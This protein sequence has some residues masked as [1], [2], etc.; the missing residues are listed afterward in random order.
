MMKRPA[1]PRILY[2]T[3]CYLLVFASLGVIQFTSGRGFSRR[4]GD[5]VITGHYRELR[6]DDPPPGPQEYPLAGEPVIA[7]GGME[8]H[9]AGGLAGGGE[10]GGLGFLDAGGEKWEA[11]PDSMVVSGTTASFYFPGGSE[12]IFSSLYTE[13]VPELRIS[14]VFAGGIS[15]AEIPYRISRGAQAAADPDGELV[16]RSG[17]KSY[18]FGR[19]Q[20]DT[21]RRVLTLRD[22]GGPVSYRG[23]R[24]K[25]AFVPEEYVVPQAQDRGRYLE[26]L[27]RWRDQ[28]YALWNRIAG[29]GGDEDLVSA[30]VGES[31]GRGTY[32]AALA[33]LSPN[34]LAA[35]ARSYQSSVYLGRMDAGLLSL[36]AFERDQTGRLIRQ[37]NDRSPDFIR[38]SHVFAYLALRGYHTMVDRGAELIRNLDSAL[39]RPDMLPGILEGFSDWVLHRPGEENPFASL[40]PQVLWEVSEGIRRLPGGEGVYFFHEGRGDLEF[41]LRLGAALAALGDD[42]EWAAWTTLGRS[43]VLSVLAPADAAGSVPRFLQISEEDGEIREVPGTERLGS[44][45]LYGILAAGGNDRVFSAAYYPRAVNTGADGL[46][47]WTAASLVEARE[48][49]GVLDIAVTFPAGEAHYM[50]LRGLR[51][52]TKIQLYDMDYRTDPQFERYDSSGWSYSRQEQTLLLKI[53][54]RG[55]VEHIRIFY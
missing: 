47:A 39:V 17:G 49:D 31:L 32:K 54:H 7:F 34:F 12:L 38:D 8:F 46:W 26:A 51:S 14:G 53:K 44:P 24:E 55:P 42:P 16:V 19:V 2:L 35:P 15:A 10:S 13:N 1:F 18:R 6:K 33:S 5:L 21:E 4:V 30:Y 36:A 29:T 52:F 11:V 28:S 20:P 50:F 25:E 43:L 37:L 45:G 41:N 3:L 48:E 22:G 9:L 40:M 27:T 23:T